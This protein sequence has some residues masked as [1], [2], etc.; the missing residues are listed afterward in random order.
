MELIRARLVE[1][2]ALPHDGLPFGNED[3]I[4]A[5]AVLVGQQNETA[6]RS[7]TGG[8]TRLDQ[9]QEREQPHDFR[10]V[11]HE[12]GKEP[13]KADGLGTKIFSNQPLA[14]AR[15][16]ALVENEV[17]DGGHRPKAGR[18][19]GLTRNTVRNSRVA[20]ITLGSNQPLGHRRFGT[21]KARAISAVVSP[22]RSRSV[23]ATWI[24]DVSAG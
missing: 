14:R 11:G 4:P 23:S 8:A 12:L 20:N 16:M 17:D 24:P 9:Q 5:I 21:R 15:R 10:F 3:T 22:P 6:L 7:E 2:K 1:P 18:E 13:S 19:V